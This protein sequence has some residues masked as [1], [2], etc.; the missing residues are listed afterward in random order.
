MAAQNIQDDEV[1][2]KSSSHLHIAPPNESF[3]NLSRSPHPYNRRGSK[4]AEVDGFPTTN[5][6]S[7]QQPWGRRITPRSSSDSGTEADDESTGLLKG[8]PA[9]PTRPRKGLRG[10]R[11]HDGSPDSTS[12]Q[13]R[14]WL[15]QRGTRSRSTAG[16][17]A[18]RLDSETAEVSRRIARRRKV[19]LL[20]RL[21][22]TF[23]LLTVGLIVVAGSGV[24]EAVRNWDRPLLTYAFLVLGIYTAY[25]LRIL[26][27]VARPLI[28][29]ASILSLIPP[30]FDPAP[31]LYP[32][33]IP[34]LVALSLA[35]NSEAFVLPNIILSLSS[36]PPPSVPH[37]D[38]HHG[39]S[40]MHWAIT[41][42]PVVF[43]EN[44]ILPLDPAIPLCLRNI[45]SELLLLIYPLHQ[46]LLPTLNYLLTTS[47]LPA[48]LQLLATALIN[49]VLFST[50]PQAE[51][52]KALLWLGGI[53]VFILCRRAL[54]W[55]VTLARVPTWKFRRPHD[56]WHFP[57]NILKT[58]DLKICQRLSSMGAP[59]EESS[60]SETPNGSRF[61]R[62]RGGIRDY[63]NP[64]DGAAGHRSF[65][66]HR[67]DTL[68][69]VAGNA[70][71]DLFRGETGE[72]IEAIHKRRHTFSSFETSNVPLRRAR[73]TP[74]GRRKRLLT[75][76][77]RSFLSLTVAQAQVRKWAYALYT[78]LVI[79][80]IILGPIRS[81]VSKQS[82]HGNEPF[83]WA[84]GYLFGDIPSFR[85]WLVRADLERWVLIPPRLD[86]GSAC[87]MGWVEHLRQDT[88][89]GAN[90]RLLISAYC[91]IVLCVGIAIVL[92][93]SSVVEVDTRRKV[94][95][96]MMVAMFLPTIFIDPSFV[97]LALVLVLAIFLLL[98]LFRAS[99]LPP[100]SK[101]LTYF[102]APYV[103]GRDHRGPVIV[104]HIFLLIGC[105]IPLWLSLSGV[106]RL[107]V[108]PWKGWEV[109][110]RDVGMVSGVICVGMGD[111]AASLIGRRYGRLKWFWGGGKSLEGSAAFAA[112]VFVGL[113]VARF[114]LVLGGWDNE[115][116]G[117]NWS[118]AMTKSL[119][120]AV[121]ASTTEAV[122]TGGNDNVIVPVVLWLLV[123]G[124][125]I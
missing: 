29:K 112:A 3:R 76:D 63:T 49:V 1:I 35:G 118:V 56:G 46:A 114:W 70:Y 22:E 103:D 33:V 111:A 109:G 26:R 66:T 106:P 88:F 75:P 74:S 78:Y 24:L 50:S 34:V 91:G 122:L 37:Y 5:E 85:F 97:A 72:T 86:P 108:H 9:P 8:L 61:I 47:L 117:D 95:H 31:L 93:L 53:L 48:E 83:G 62:K 44:D 40:L 116:L 52:L 99:Q 57:R 67:S 2:A 64:M 115:G 69:S 21:S 28:S 82:L 10:I 94:F 105:A 20:R 77:V 80:L 68:G 90:T 14:L 6:E 42:T 60:D 87:H 45:D 123:R 18:G 12:A 43:A 36:L 104:S 79:L 110:S 19:E 38:T 7:F 54:I 25:P 102:L 11:E 98:D 30:S 81:Y 100:I 23:L 120:A 101:P 55:E 17:L 58:L 4:L 121:G 41:I 71:S 113:I 16:G 13:D 65:E 92:R 15:L 73:T 89:G 27:N 125:Q 51:I 59:D 32:V 96:G 119:V 39:F 124:L 107:G 84:A